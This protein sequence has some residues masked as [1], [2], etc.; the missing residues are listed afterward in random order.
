[1]KKCSVVCGYRPIIK[2]KYDGELIGVDRGAL[3]L[4][5]N[6]KEIDISMLKSYS[7]VMM[8]E[9]SILYKD[10][11]PEVQKECDI[12]CNCSSFDTACE[13]VRGK[14]G[15]SIVGLSENRINDEYNGVVFRK[16]KKQDE[17]EYSL[18]CIVNSDNNN[19][20]IIKLVNDVYSI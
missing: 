7:I 9:E 20:N 12:A 2:E 6:N 17:H 15:L 1:M 19:P 16:Y 13:L 8:T 18:A 3:Y 5:K 10:I 11:N 4:A 14:V